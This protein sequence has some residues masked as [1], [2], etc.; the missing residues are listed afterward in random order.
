MRF[1][2]SSF[3]LRGLVAA[4]VLALAATTGSASA[5]PIGPGGP[6]TTLQPLPP[7][8][9]NIDQSV[10]S[11]LFDIG[12]KFLRTLGNEA[13][14][15]STG[16]P[17]SNNPAGGG[18]DMAVPVAGSARDPRYRAWFEGYG[19][20]SHM[21]PQADFAGDRRR[22]WGGVAG[23]GMTVMPG[24]SVG[25]SVDQS[26]T[27]VNNPL[28]QS[29]TIDLTQ[30]GGNVA[31]DS[32]PWTLALA[33]VGGFAGV[34]TWRPDPIGASIANYDASIWGA[35]GELSYLW[36]SGNWRVVPKLGADWTRVHADAFS[37]TGGSAPLSAQAQTSRR[38]R[39]FAALEV[40]HTWFSGN[41][42]FDLSGYA[43]L[44]DIVSQD[45]G[46]LNLAAT[47]FLPLAVQ[48]VSESRTGIDAGAAA[49]WRLS[50]ALR[51][52]A[53]YDGRFRSN[54]ESHG[55]TVGLELR[56]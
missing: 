38:T 55:G 24:M 11:A 26:R 42:M 13:A 8:V 50:Q 45:L 49:S 48:G 7:T 22:T 3:D 19:I 46:T 35:L 10:P 23:L 43:R 9:A 1:V 25:I 21:D 15:L 14:W 4:A 52:Y 18:A 31:F 17:L 56:W 16:A 32:G 34:D 12:S 33:G 36:S 41:T 54:F 39:L 20:A 29:A 40:G 27:K 6:N 30:I 47:G 51:L 2:H 37:E 53:V 44:V 28:A 5:Q